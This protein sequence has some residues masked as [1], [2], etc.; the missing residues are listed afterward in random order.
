MDQN[1]IWNYFQQEGND[2]FLQSNSRLNYLF[3]KALKMFGDTK[4]NALNIG[5]GNGQIEKR[6]LQQGWNIYSLDPS[7][8]A[9]RSLEKINIKGKVG[10]VEKNPYADDFFNIVFCSEV[11]EHLSD[12]QLKL[13]VLEIERVLKK[14][15]VLIGT[16]PYKEN[17]LDNQVVCP[18]CGDI[19]HKWGH[20]Q[21]FDIESLRKIFPKTLTVQRISILY[22]VNWESLS[23][24]GVL[25]SL[26]K[27][28]LA[29]LGIHGSDE[30]LFFIVKK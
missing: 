27:K 5:F 18:K 24:K 16:V 10:Y 1:K 15:G 3:K 14:G 29:M 28:G 4:P 6:C 8:E 23:W 13:G 25:S 7:Q 26:I 21:S 19:F 17:L 20:Q 11:I 9:I 12:E 30:N 22:F 2:V